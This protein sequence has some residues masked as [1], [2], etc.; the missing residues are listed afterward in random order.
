LATPPGQARINGKPA[1]WRNA[2]PELL[3]T[4]RPATILISR[5]GDAKQP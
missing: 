5:S 4:E 1:R 3:I 2:L